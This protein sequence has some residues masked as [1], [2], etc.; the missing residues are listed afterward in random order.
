MKGFKK[1]I[2][3]GLSTLMLASTGMLAGCG[4]GGGTSSS[5]GAN[6][7]GGVNGEQELQVYGINK[8]YGTQWC[9]DLLDLFAQQQWV[10]DKYPELKILETYN[11]VDS[12][13]SDRINSP[14]NN[15]YDLFFG[16]SLNDFAG[17]DN[18]GNETLVDLTTLLYEQTVPGESVK[19][20]DKLLQSYKDTAVY[21]APNDPEAEDQYYTT[22]WAGGMNSFICNPDILAKYGIT[23]IN[24]TDELIAACDAIKATPTNSGNDGGYS[25]LRAGNTGYWTYLFYAWWAQYDGI[26]NYINFY[27]GIFMDGDYP[28][29][30]NRIFE[31]EGRLKALE[32]FEQLLDYDKGYLSPKS[33][34][35]ENFMMCQMDMYEGEYAFM[36]NGDWFDDEMRE[37][38]QLMKDAGET[39]ARLEMMK[40]P[41]V[42]S[43]IEKCEKV[44]D[45]AELSALISAIDAGN[46]ALKGEGYDV[47]QADYDRIKE[48]RTVVHSIG[49]NHMAAI[50]SVSKSKEVA[51]DF[52][53]FM[54][55]DIAQE[56]YIRTTTGASLPF[57]YNLKEKNETLYNEISPLQQARMDYFCNEAYEVYSL[58]ITTYFP[59]VKYGELSAIANVERFDNIFAAQGNQTTAKDLFDITTSVW[60]V[61]AFEFA[62]DRA[63][64]KFY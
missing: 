53:L 29:Y 62:L 42:S 11:D 6:G 47:T 21:R 54:A 13:A 37:L 63:G 30:S 58:P 33:F 61:E 12:F 23:T 22:F 4:G 36:V 46:T 31:L 28:V 15:T 38:V 14:S 50:P 10:K 8:G 2:C 19:Y 32:I 27:N 20:K 5:G 26:Q 52:L 51:I 55:T 49:P 34:T 64:L 48:A 44:E 25:F 41:I 9:S 56:Q 35:E 1:G 18:A 16:M 39:P 45:D 43:I 7:T 59:L 57:R 17:K 24:T 3:L 60:T 40:L